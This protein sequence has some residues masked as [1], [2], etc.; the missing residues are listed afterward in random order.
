VVLKTSQNVPQNVPHTLMNFKLHLHSPS[1]ETSA[2]QLHTFIDKKRVKISTGISVPTKAWDSK[3]QKVRPINPICVGLQDQLTDFTNN[4]S[5]IFAL[6][7]VQGVEIT[8]LSFKDAV[9]RMQSRK[10]GISEASLTFNQWVKEFIQET[11]EGKR[12]N[13]MG[14]PI[15]ERTVQKYRTVKDQLDTFAVKVW[16]REI[17]FEDVDAKFL[18]AF[19]KFRGDQGLGVNTIAKDQA[20]LKTWMKESYLRNVHENKSFQTKA[21]I[22]KEIKVRKPTLTEDELEILW[23]HDF[24]GRGKY[25]GEK[26]ALT[27]CR[28]HFIIACWTGVRISDLKR[29]P[30]II[31]DAWKQS[32]DKCPEFLTFTQS[33]TK[34]QVTLP[35]LPELCQ[36]ITKWKGNIPEVSAE[37]QMN[38]KIKE[39]CKIA[40]LD[41]KIDK[42]STKMSDG[43][44]IQRVPLHELVSNH[45]ARRT[46]ATNIY[47]R[48][49]LSNGALMSLTGHNSEGAFLKY[50]DMTQE[51]MSKVAGMQLLKA[52]NQDRNS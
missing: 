20:V 14:L 5:K 25:G 44:K 11:E 22:P 18:E 41:R 39:A 13:Q 4:V 26:T 38:T 16:G 42:V 19:K 8:P 30:E 10:E 49:I 50:L 52:I 15:N 47:K 46:F 9:N 27:K 32:G 48:G 34:T 40:G 7:T 33:K 6:M 3:K 23:R 43:G 28:D 1:K 35:V 17:R 31:R 24:S 29:M 36:V 45:T 2:V 51:E 37:Q 21:F 12:T